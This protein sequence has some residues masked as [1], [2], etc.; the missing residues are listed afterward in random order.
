MKTFSYKQALDVL[1]TYFCGYKIINKRVAT[2]PLNQSQIS[3]FTEDVLKL[4]CEKA[5]LTAWDIYNVATEIYKP[6]RSDFPTIIPQNVA[7]VETI[8]TFLS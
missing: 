4:A 7:F 6:E 8:E 5:Q 3:A 1:E 2:Y